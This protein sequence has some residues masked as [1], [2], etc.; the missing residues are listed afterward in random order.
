[1]K[2]IGVKGIVAGK[3]ANGGRASVNDGIKRTMPVHEIAL[4]QSPISLDAGSIWI[5]SA[6]RL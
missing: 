5:H 3:S 6:G 4:G 2:I 1:M